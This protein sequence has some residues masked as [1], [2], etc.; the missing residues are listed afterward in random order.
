MELQHKS[1]PA[2]IPGGGGRCALLRQNAIN[3]G[4]DVIFAPCATT[5]AAQIITQ[6]ASAGFDKPITAGD[7]WESSVILDAQK[8]TS[9]QVYCSTF[10]D[11]NDDSGAAKEFVTGFKEWL[12]ADSQKL[13][14]NGGNDIV[15]AV[16]ALGY[17]GYM[18]ALEA[19]KAAGSTDGTAI[20]DALYG[21]N[22]DG[23]TGN[24]TFDQT[25]G[26]ANKDMAYIKK[27]ADGAFEFVKTQ[28][29]EG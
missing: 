17:D 3:A 27:A 9:V 10:F 12:N 29:V 23:V 11:E 8:G 24:I 1:R 21:V 2:V 22:Y 19:I 6:A 28:S 7:T 20:R 13:T 4:A 26:D 15:A 16:S 25:T 14:N 5:Y 18:V